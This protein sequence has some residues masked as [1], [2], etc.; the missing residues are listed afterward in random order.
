MHLNLVRFI[1]EFEREAALKGL[2]RK[3]LGHS[4][5]IFLKEVW[6]PA[7]HYNY[8]GLKAEYPLKDF[9]GGQRFA[10][11]VYI[12]NGVKLLIEIDG[13]TTHARDISPGDFD[14]HLVRQNDL[15]LSGW[16]VIRFSS[17]Q[18]EK[19]SH[20]CQRQLKQ[21]L[22]H[23]WSL[24]HANFSAEDADIWKVRKHLVIQLAMRLNGKI[25]PC[26]I[27]AQFQIGNRSAV[28]WLKRFTAEGEFTS[29]SS[30]K[31]TTVYYLKDYVSM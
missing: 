2:Y 13:F 15:I 18:V 1:E 5:L 12:R 19:R 17:H 10:D 25:K 4:E 9:K 23:W 6:G 27:A 20:I 11:F 14:D 24:T 31:R 29:T 7:F 8:D 21:A 16:L 30:G 26:E 22:G 28:D 3:Q